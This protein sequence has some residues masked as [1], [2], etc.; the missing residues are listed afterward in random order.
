MKIT[1]GELRKR[2]E[3]KKSLQWHRNGGNSPWHREK[4]E[5]NSSPVWCFYRKQ[6][7]R[8]RRLPLLRP[9]GEP[10][11]TRC[12]SLELRRR[13]GSSTARSV[14]PQRWTRLHVGAEVS[15]P[16]L[17]IVTSRQA[18]ASAPCQIVA[19]ICS[20]DLSFSLSTL[21]CTFLFNLQRSDRKN[22]LDHSGLSLITL[23]LTHA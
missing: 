2:R 3:K 16:R 23:K 8:G 9:A 19:Q 21:M 13:L 5:I 10:W 12:S 20:A 7:Y 6:T 1:F 22:H 17:E 4:K 14:S 11:T 18:A 15:L